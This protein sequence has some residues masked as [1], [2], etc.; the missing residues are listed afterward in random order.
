MNFSGHIGIFDF[1][2]MK[3]RKY[4]A[5]LG[6]SWLHKWNLHIE[7]RANTVKI[8]VGK[9]IAVLDGL[10]ASD[11]KGKLSSVFRR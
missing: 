4:D 11:R 9:R 5:I 2:L 1:Y 6:K 10:Q 7:W 3:L 8:K